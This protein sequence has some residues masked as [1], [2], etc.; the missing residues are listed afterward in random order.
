MRDERMR[1]QEGR[2]R[3]GGV[4]VLQQAQVTAQQLEWEGCQDN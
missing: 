2:K 3:E 4:V 1:P